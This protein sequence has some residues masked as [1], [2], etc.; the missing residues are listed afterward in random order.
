MSLPPASVAVPVSFAQTLDRRPP[1]SGERQYNIQRSAST[2]DIS[3]PNMFSPEQYRALREGSGLVDRSHRGR[4]RL[5]GPDRRDYLQGLLTNDIARLEAGQG[6]YA[7]LLTAQGRMIA[8]MYVI[9]TGE[10]I[11]LDVE[12][13]DVE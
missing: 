1:A 6:C 5:I 4:L 12:P 10:A 2:E 13:Q 7:C 3:T 11:I 9:E 8:D